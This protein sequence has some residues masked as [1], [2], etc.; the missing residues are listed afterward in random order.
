VKE[1]DVARKRIGLTM[2]SGAIDRAASAGGTRPPA[3]AP[4][5]RHSA[6][7]PKTSD[8]P[9]E[10]AFAAAMRRAQERK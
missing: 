4:G 5:P 10:S 2:R 9:A 8:A 7:P 1:V 3:P 6:P